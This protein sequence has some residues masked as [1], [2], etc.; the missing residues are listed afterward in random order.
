MILFKCHVNNKI[1]WGHLF[2]CISIATELKKFKKKSILFS[3]GG[4]KI[5]KKININPFV[6]C[7]EEKTLTHQS[8][9][10][11]NLLQIIKKQKVKKIIID[12]NR[13]N[14]NIRRK[15]KSLGCKIIQLNYDFNKFKNADIVINHRVTKNELDKSIK[16]Y[17]GIKFLIVRKNL[18]NKINYKKFKSIKNII[19]TFGGSYNNKTI[20]LLKYIS[21]LK[22]LHN[23]KLHIILPN[24]KI[25][26]TL[27]VKNNKYINF[28]INP[29]FKIIKKIY[30]ICEMGICA[31][32]IQLAE[33]INNQINVLAIPKNNQ[34]RK[35][36]Y[37]YT[38]L[39]LCHKL[40]DDNL[41]YLEIKKKIIE[42]IKNL[43]SRKNI[44]QNIIKLIDGNGAFRASKIILSDN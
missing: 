7:Y 21:E 5:L 17:N 27:N 31:G 24:K 43:T 33:L 8:K 20:K 44:N 40:K 42:L 12:D 39:N 35:N 11:Y 32:G 18:V 41:S 37:F 9:N 38:K 4:N 36:I 10:I 16:L 26:K 3:S 1:G 30:R 34:E 2:R 19:L 22:I 28:Y 14:S 6:M 29:N 25:Q 13:I 23:Y 15:I